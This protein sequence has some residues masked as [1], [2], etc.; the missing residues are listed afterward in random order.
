MVTVSLIYIFKDLILAEAVCLKIL[1][2]LH[3]KMKIRA[4]FDQLY[5]KYC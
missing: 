4:Y 1:G 2:L 3:L 5:F